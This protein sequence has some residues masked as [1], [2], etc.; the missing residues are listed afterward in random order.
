MEI[1]NMRYSDLK[2]GDK[3]ILH[4]SD[5]RYEDEIK[6]V[7]SVG[8]KWVKLEDFYKNVKFSVLDGKANDALPGYEILIPKSSEEQAWEKTYSY[9]IREVAPR[10]LKT[11]SLSKLEHLQRRWTKKILDNDDNNSTI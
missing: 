3:V 5:T 2:P 7:K 6:V 8:L 10:Y 4:T 11:L 9:L 1:F